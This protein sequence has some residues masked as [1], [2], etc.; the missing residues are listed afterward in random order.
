MPLQNI[1]SYLKFIIKLGNEINVKCDIVRT[2]SNELIAKSE[3]G[4]IVLFSTQNYGYTLEHLIYI[5]KLYPNLTDNNYSL[6][7]LINLWEEKI[8]F[9][10]EKHIPSIKKDDYYY[11]Y[12]I[13]YAIHIIG[14][15]EN[16]IQYVKDVMLD[17]KINTMPLTISHRRLKSFSFI[18]FLDPFNIVIDFKGR[19]YAEL[20]KNKLITNEELIDVIKKE[21]MTI[22]DISVM[23]ARILFPSIYFDLF[24]HSYLSHNDIRNKIIEL[25]DHIDD[26]YKNLTLLNSLLV[27]NFKIRNINWLE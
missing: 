16:A 23:F 2:R 3:E 11:Q 6:D 10:E 15:A 26:Y 9:I 20:Y 12:T 17:Y 18:E 21:N 22:I 1:T 8:K 7:Y 13:K 27:K 24:E 4:H 19:D 5:H 14:L 25:Y